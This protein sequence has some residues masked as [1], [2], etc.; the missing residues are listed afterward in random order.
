M[1]GKQDCFRNG[2]A[3]LRRQGIVE[4]LI[5]R[6]PPER[7]VDDNGAPEDSVLEIGAIEGD[8]VGDAIDDHPIAARLRHPDTADVD[9]F[10]IHIRHPQGI[11]PLYH[12]TGEG[13]LHPVDNPDFPHNFSIIV[14][15]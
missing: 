1:V 6:A 13:I 7:V 11:D 15:M 3:D 8:I 12:R 4:E 2:N 9:V 10:G 14:Q 5:V